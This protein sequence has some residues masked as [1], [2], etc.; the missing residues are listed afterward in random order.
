MCK[1]PKRLLIVDDEIFNLKTIEMVLR[2]CGFEFERAYDGSEAY[3][4]F[5]KRMDAN[6]CGC[7]CYFT[8]VLMDLNMPNMD[9]AKCSRKMLDYVV[10]CGKREK[11]LP[12]IALS[13]YTDQESMNYCMGNGMKAFINKPMRKATIL[14]LFGDLGLWP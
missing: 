1:C 14:N 5:C 6:E 3:P 12:V 8:A 4:L 11:D 7:C 9:G 10:R 2:G 13:A